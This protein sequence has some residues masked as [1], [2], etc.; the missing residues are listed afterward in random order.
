MIRFSVQ[1]ISISWVLLLC[2]PGFGQLSDTSLLSLYSRPFFYN[3]LKGEDGKIYTGTSEGIFRMDGAGFA[4]VDKRVGYI[5]QDEKGRLQIDSNGIK[6][7]EEKSFSRLLPFPDRA[8]E[9]Y[10][11]GT[12]DHFYIVSG[13][14]MHVYEILPY[15]IRYP[16]HSVRS[17]SQNF[18]GT[19]SGIYHKGGR[20]E[21][22]PKFTDG[23]IREFN[24]KV[25]ICYSDLFI[26]DLHGGDTLPTKL[27]ENPKGIEY[28]Y[29]SDILFSNTLNCYY[30]ATKNQLGTID[31]ELTA[32][33]PL[34]TQKEKDGEVVLL[35][36]DRMDILFASGRDLMVYIPEQDSSRLLTSLPEQILDAEITTQNI[37]VLCAKGLYVTNREGRLEKLLTLNK[38]HTLMNIGNSEWVISTDVG[39]LHYNATTKKLS[40]LIR[41]VEF[42]RRGLYLEGD[43]LYAGSINGLYVFDAKNLGSLAERTSKAAKGQPLPPYVVPAFAAMAVLTLALSFLLYRSRNRL[44]QVIEESRLVVEPP[45]VGKHDIEA[46]IRENLAMASLKSITDHFQTHTKYI[47]SVLDP[48]KP[49]AF[50]NRLRMEQVLQMRKENKSAR[51]ISEQTG[52]SESYVR[53]VWNQERQVGE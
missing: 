33:R 35:G 4:K 30:I 5:A 24:G 34:Y 6:Y 16:N 25:F 23:Y 44:N 51:E 49:G 39:L 27:K 21:E 15:G 11:A 17:V 13:G 53:K 12:E 37:H 42:N 46:F 26:A 38:A 7:H 48:E 40:E 52:F 29:T 28:H 1:I 8:R 32:A 43:R 14:R 18:V 3:V 10:H 2:Q 45:K 47:Y 41:G 20:L 22:G 50:I 9:E 31:R 19:Y 36:Q